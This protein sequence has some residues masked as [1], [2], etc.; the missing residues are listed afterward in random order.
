[1]L[2]RIQVLAVGS[3]VLPRRRA[4][5][6]AT[7]LQPNDA[8][9]ATATHA[10]MLRNASL[11]AAAP[12]SLTMHVVVGL[13]MRNRTGADLLLRRE[14]TPGDPLYHVKPSPAQCRV[15]AVVAVRD[16]TRAVHHGRQDDHRHLDVCRRE[17]LS[18]GN[19]GERGELAN[20]LEPK[21]GDRKSGLFNGAAFPQ[22]VFR[23]DR[24]PSPDER[25]RRA[26]RAADDSELDIGE[27]RPV[28]F[29]RPRKML[30]DL[31]AQAEKSD[32]ASA[33]KRSRRPAGFC[34]HFAKQVAED[35]E[36]DNAVC[37]AHE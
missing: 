9:A 8:L 11:M 36:C 22:V 27:I 37:L 17:R 10:T 25:N 34:A 29:L 35:G 4:S 15:F 23:L 28:A 32:D 1:M 14:H 12:P 19:Y 16:R 18:G 30:R 13:A 2:R 3:Y 7:R 20:R 33:D 31:D 26:D 6:R 24:Q 21:T 5:R